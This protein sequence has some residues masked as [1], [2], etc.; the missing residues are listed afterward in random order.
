MNGLKNAFA[1][2]KVARFFVALLMATPLLLALAACGDGSSST[3]SDDTGPLSSAGVQNNSSDSSA[4][5]DGPVCGFSKADNVW[6]YSY[7]SWKYVKVYTWVDESTVEYKEYMNDFHM[8]RN[9]ATYTG[10][11]RDEFYE[12]V[13]KECLEDNEIE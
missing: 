13:M 5:E 12:K 4:K 11:N 2:R 1:N 10:V 8:D 3:S 9:D 7:S 6:K